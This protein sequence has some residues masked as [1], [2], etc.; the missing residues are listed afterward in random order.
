MSAKFGK[1]ISGKVTIEKGYTLGS[2][3]ATHKVNEGDGYVDQVLDL[4]IEF[5]PTEDGSLVYSYSYEMPA[6]DITVTFNAVA[7]KNTPFIVNYHFENVD[8]NGYDVE[9][10]EGYTGETGTV[11]TEDMLGIVDGT[12]QNVRE[13]F[14]YSNNDLMSNTIIAGDGSTVVN[15][16]FTRIRTKLSLEITDPYSGVEYSTL[17]VR[18][19]GKLAVGEEADED[20]PNIT[21]TTYLYEIAYGQTIQVSFELANEHFKTEGFTTDDLVKDED[22]EL[23]VG[24]YRQEGTTIDYIHGKKDVKL[25][26]YIDADEVNYTVRYF[27]QNVVPIEDAGEEDSNNY[28]LSAVLIATGTGHVNEVLNSNISTNIIEETYIKNI[29]TVANYDATKF[30][31]MDLTS[32][33]YKGTYGTGT[34]FEDGIIR[35]MADDST[36][37]NIYFNRKIIDINVDLDDNFG[38]VDGDKQYVYGDTVTITATTEPGYDFETLTINGTNVEKGAE[39]L[40]VADGENNTEVVTYTFKLNSTTIVED[41]E[42]KANKVD[43]KM[44]SVAGKANF[45]VLVY[46]ENIQT[47]TYG[48]P[49]SYTV[50]GT[51]GAVLA[52]ELFDDYLITEK[53]G[54]T[55]PQWVF[56]NCDRDE[57]DNPLIKGDESSVV[58]IRFNLQD[59]NFEIELG[60]G[61]LSFE[62]SSMYNTLRILQNTESPYTYEAKY[63]EILQNFVINVDS[64]RYIYDGI[65]IAYR[66]EEDGTWVDE[67]P[68][69]DFESGYLDKV[70]SVTETRYFKLIVKTE[71]IDIT[72]IYDPNNGQPVSVPEGYEYGDEATIKTIEE[73]GF[74]NA[75]YNFLGWATEA[76]GE[77]VYKPGEKVAM[78]EPLIL[79]AVWEEI[80]GIAWWIYLVIGLGIL[81]LII[82][83]IIIIIVVKK[84][85][86]KEKHK[87]A[88]K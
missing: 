21:I 32:F 31:G 59:I 33:W 88:S 5:A 54:Y 9:K 12:M 28:S 79:Y 55:T 63:G 57:E 36:T 85:K 68:L 23:T 27:T 86:D 48:E 18:V 19:N 80:P 2:I 30:E 78:T 26:I 24:E 69:T 41:A 43:V 39:G 13:G 75:G 49:E 84:K 11:I 38:N 34:A 50:E 77:V 83:L 20:A 52:R 67:E 64:S 8:L 40:T 73:L 25:S 81:L 10:Q 6:E 1:T 56:V 3:T 58:E 15:V 87:I 14:E 22:D 46:Y 51:T 66:A 70:F 35:V 60:E 72:I 62:V 61:V 7:D 44:T 47:L 29:E 53:L 4:D 37:V 45:T 74:E 16:Y 42:T 17:T 76:G 82:I 71:E 65:S